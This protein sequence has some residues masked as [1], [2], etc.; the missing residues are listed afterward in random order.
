VVACGRTE[1]EIDL[2]STSSVAGVGG[3][4]TSGGTASV[5]GSTTIGGT[6]TTATCTWGFGPPTAYAAGEA[7]ETIA[8]ADFDRDGHPDLAVKNYGGDPGGHTLNT[9]HNRGDGT[10]TAWES[11]DGEQPFNMI[12]G[13][14][15]SDDSPDLI[16][17][18]QLYPCGAD[19]SLGSPVKYGQD[20]P[21]WALVGPGNLVAADFDGDGRSDVAWGTGR[22]A[23]LLNRGEG[24]FDEVDTA[25]AVQ[26]IAV[27]DFDR[28]GQPDLAAVSYGYG[29]PSYLKI[30][31]NTGNGTFSEVDIELGN[32]NLSGVA[33]GDLDGDGWPD[34]VVPHEFEFTMQ[35]LLNDRGGRFGPPASYDAGFQVRSIALGDLDGD[36]TNDV[37]GADRGSGELGVFL[38]RGDGTLAP[39]QRWTIGTDPE[40]VALG[41][42]NSDGHLDVAAAGASVWGVSSVTVFLSQCR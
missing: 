10:F 8:I 29:N 27:A 37:V 22:I 40:S 15:I 38:N 39:K 3:S 23:V 14:F 7:P 6:A 21:C 25:T 11:Y 26:S 33:A 12:A 4:T 13:P 32:D 19:G 36:G 1:L 35:V 30:M 20:S 41:D 9:L 31:R 28:D 34:I 18:C 24:H 42:L 16:V 17:G 5:G 2:P